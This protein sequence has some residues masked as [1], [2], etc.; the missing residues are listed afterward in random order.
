MNSRRLSICIPLN[1][2][3]SEEDFIENKVEIDKDNL[4]FPIIVDQVREV[5]VFAPVVW[6]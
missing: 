1:C 4:V 2:T 6:R 5:Y 3:N